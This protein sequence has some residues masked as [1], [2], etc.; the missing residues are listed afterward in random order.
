MVLSLESID[1]CGTLV[2][3]AW[4]RVMML[5]GELVN[6]LLVCDI[7]V[8]KLMQPVLLLAWVVLLEALYLAA[9]ALVVSD[10]VLLVRAVLGGIMLDAD[11]RLSYVD[12]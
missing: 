8:L 11:A 2:R 5:S 9:E 4:Q 12:L 1:L 7:G 3:K 10:Q 6:L